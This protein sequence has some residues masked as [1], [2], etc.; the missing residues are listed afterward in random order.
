MSSK[1]EAPTEGTAIPTSGLAIAHSLGSL[2]P[3]RK[4]T[5]MFDYSNSCES[6]SFEEA[7]ATVFTW[8]FLSPALTEDELVEAILRAHTRLYESLRDTSSIVRFHNDLTQLAAEVA[9]IAEA[10]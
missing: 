1:T 5:A 4:A 6:T 3:T 7:D 2:R 8:R 10:V 9:R